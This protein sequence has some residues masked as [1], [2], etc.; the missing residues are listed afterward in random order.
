[1]KLNTSM[2]ED[3]TKLQESIKEGKNT[4][5]K[6]YR[7]DTL[8][9]FIKKLIDSKDKNKGESEYEKLYQEAYTD[10]QNT[11][12]KYQVFIQELKDLHKEKINQLVEDNSQL[13]KKYKLLLRI[14]YIFVVILIVI[15]ILS[16]TIL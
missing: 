1:M 11:L 3:L 12:D 8:L 16:I 6:K 7:K 14:D 10:L 4:D 9:N 2:E 5:I 13:K 15:L